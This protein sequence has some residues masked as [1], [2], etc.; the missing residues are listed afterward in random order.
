MKA[1]KL[2]LSIDDMRSKIKY[3]CWRKFN[4]P[5]MLQHIT[6]GKRTEVDALN[7]AIVREGKKLG[8]PTPYNDALT[9]LIKG[10]EKSRRQALLDTPIDYDRMEAEAAADKSHAAPAGA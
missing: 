10:L 8:I 7:G 3:Q 2:P 5:S 9:L 1:K 4:K 6:A